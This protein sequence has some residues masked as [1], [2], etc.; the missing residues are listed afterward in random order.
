MSIRNTQDKRHFSKNTRGSITVMFALMLTLVFAFVGLAIDFGRGYNA[1]ADLQKT[2]DSVMLAAALES[3]KDDG[4]IQVTANAF[5]AANWKDNYGSATPPDLIITSPEPGTVNGSISLDIPTYFL[6]VM[7]KFNLSVA[8]TGA[9]NMSVGNVEVALV[10]DNTGSMSGSKLTSLKDAA[11]TLVDI[12][13]PESG[14]F[15]NVKIG[16]VPFSQ[17]VNV[18]MEYRDESW[19]D[20]A[21]DSSNPV[22]W[23]TYPDKV[24]T[25][26]TTNSNG[27]C[28]NDGVPYTC[29]QTSCDTDWGDPVQECGTDY[30]SWNGCVAS[31]DHPKNVKDIAPGIAIPGPLDT[32]CA[33]PL[34]RLTNDRDEIINKIDGMIA[35]GYTYI[36]SGLMWG[37]RVLSSAVP[38]DDGVTYDEMN[39]GQG[40]RKVVVLMTDGANTR[41]PDYDDQDHSDSDIDEADSLTAEV[42]ENIKEKNI[43]IYTVT[44]DIVDVALKDLMENCA[45]TT[46]NFFDAD[47]PAEL[48]AA[49][50]A[51]GSSLAQL[52]IT[53]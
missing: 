39:G 18:G 16:L 47:N 7:N 48:S 9:V 22:C 24:E 20:V 21:A 27:T 13:M 49:F 14:T 4:D 25:N 8:T 12:L 17:Y 10:L 37:W 50:E 30:L 6:P 3:L 32:S 29:S 2:L 51:I 34:T 1:R 53:N 45:T 28:Y 26:C 52:R 43:E 38:F 31:R 44:F 42:C 19:L 23:N 41:S 35:T 5:L 11:T 15:D 46:A 40:V 36:P 33:S